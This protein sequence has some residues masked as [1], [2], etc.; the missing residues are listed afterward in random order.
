M[1]RR[2]EDDAVHPRLV[3][4]DPPPLAP[5]LLLPPLELLVHLLQAHLDVLE[6][7]LLLLEAHLAG[8]AND[9]TGTSRGGAPELLDPLDERRGGGGGGGGVWRSGVPSNGAIDGAAELEVGEW[10][11]ASADAG[12]R[13][14]GAGGGGGGGSGGGSGGGG[15]GRYR[16]AAAAVDDERRRVL[17]VRGER[18][19]VGRRGGGRERGRVG[20]AGGRAWR[21]RR[22]RRHRVD[23]GDGEQR[24]RLRALARD[25]ADGLGVAG[26]AERRRGGGGGGRVGAEVW[27][28]AD[29]KEAIVALG[30]EQRDGELERGAA[31][32]HPRGALLGGELHAVEGGEERRL[33]K[34]GLVV[35]HHGGVV[36]G[37]GHRRDDGHV[38]G[39]VGGQVARLVQEVD[40][41]HELPAARRLAPEHGEDVGALADA[42]GL[43]RHRRDQARSGLE[44]KGG[45][46]EGGAAATSAGGREFPKQKSSVSSVE[47]ESSSVESSKL[48]M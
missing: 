40:V 43:G 4:A 32:H 18:P 6:R 16:G 46:L 13:F 41:E 44:M 3:L 31:G 17:L 5:Q 24:R 25:A 14:E 20:V 26:R 9:G 36:V 34:E 33:R 45:R 39:H 10:E 19:G 2:L 42:H 21:R 7:L 22:W 37:V 38:L 12:I 35:A 29:A 1:N 27:R 15:G 11:V 23:D 48:E 8:A 28:E 47:L 30:A